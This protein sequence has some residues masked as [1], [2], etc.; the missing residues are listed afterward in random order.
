MLFQQIKKR[1]I[2]AVEQKIYKKE[3]QD[4]KQIV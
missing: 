4:C 1:Y 3:N 2:N